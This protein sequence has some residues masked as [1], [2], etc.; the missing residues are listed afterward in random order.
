ML[1][2]EIPRV[3]DWGLVSISEWHEVKSSHIEE[4]IGFDGISESGGYGLHP[5][6]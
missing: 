4:S 5:G 1:V 3:A 6:H 2:A